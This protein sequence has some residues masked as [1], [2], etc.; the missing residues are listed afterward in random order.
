M[1]AKDFINYCLDAYGTE[2]EYKT[3]MS[4]LAAS[5][6]RYG[7]NKFERNGYEFTIS[8]KT[9]NDTT[10]CSASMYCPG[11]KQTYQATTYISQI[12]HSKISHWNSPPD[13]FDDPDLVMLKLLQ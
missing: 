12:N 7:T 3:Y 6:S 4:V 2:G 9:E 13:D 1:E 8:V 5:A 10:M 11:S